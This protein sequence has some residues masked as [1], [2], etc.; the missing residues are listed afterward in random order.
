MK[1]L[2]GAFTLIELMISISIIAITLNLA[3]P[4]FGEIMDRSK[5]SANVQRLTQTLQ[6]SRLKAISSNNKVT[7][8]PIDSGL[9]CSRDWST[10]YMSFV[11]NNGD[12]LYNSDDELL[13]QYYSEDEKFSLSWRAFG[14]KNS[15]Q[16][17]GT[18]IT[19]HQNGSFELCYDNKDD[20]SRALFL[21]KAG[22]IRHSK[23]TDGDD[24]HENSTGGVISC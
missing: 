24:I 20:M 1:R 13:S 7:L 8:C 22:R 10:G 23:D 21:T 5:V 6:S 11:D 16:W 15:L 3:I 9:V 2:N 17:T 4:S 19:N 14:Y 18:G 12:R